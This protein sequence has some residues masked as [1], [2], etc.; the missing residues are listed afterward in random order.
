[1]ETTLRRKRKGQQNNMKLGYTA[2]QDVRSREKKG[3]DGRSC[4]PYHRQ[5]CVAEVMVN[6]QGYDAPGEVLCGRVAHLN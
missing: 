6:M 2:A 1:M 5:S 4:P 3:Q